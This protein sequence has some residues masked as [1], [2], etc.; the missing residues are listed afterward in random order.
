MKT[1]FSRR[2]FLKMSML[3]LG[4]AYLT[5]CGKVLSPTPP[6]SMVAPPAALPSQPTSTPV[7]PRPTSVPYVTDEPYAL[8]DFADS[9][10][11]VSD[12]GIYGI[13]SGLNSVKVNSENVNT[14]Y[15]TGQQSLEASGTIA[16]PSGSNLSIEFNVQK[17][18]GSSSYDFSNKVLVIDVFIPADSPVDWIYLEADSGARNA[19]I[20][21][22][23]I[24][25]PN[26]PPLV[27]DS[28]SYIVSLPKGQWVEAVLDIKD[29][30]SGNNPND[31]LWYASGPGG[32]LTGADALDVVKNCDV[33]KICG[34]RH[35]D[36][37]P[38][39]T[40]FLLDDLRWLERDSIKIDTSVDSLRKYAAS[41]HL[42]VG[43]YSDSYYLFGI[44][45]PKVAQA[46]PQEFNLIEF[47]SK[48]SDV[49]PSEGVFDFTKLDAMVDY[50]AGNQLAAFGYTDAENTFLPTWLWDKSFADLGPILTDYIDKVVGR[51]RGK[52]AIWN[53]FNEVVNNDGTGLRNRQSP[54]T[55][56]V[57]NGGS[58]W[59]D[60][61]DA[62][63]IK[64]AFKQARISDPGAKLLLNDY[65]TEEI[66]RRKSEFFY[67]LVKEWVK[68]GVPID[69]V[70]FEMHIEYP[71]VTVANSDWSTPRIMD[72]PAY[73]KRV[74][75]NVK[76]FADLG[77]QVVFS[78]VDVPML[79]KD[80]NPST[81]A[82]QTELKHR[83]DYEAQIFG[84]L[85]K[86]ALDNPNVIIFNTF[87]YTDKYSD[88][89]TPEWGWTG[90]GYPDLLDDHFQPKPAYVEVLKALKNQQ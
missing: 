9:F 61:N 23:K 64:A 35:T 81:S 47:S 17:Y 80:I 52:I 55:G 88:V 90:Y 63:L 53:V 51:Y 19:Q 66:G 14:I 54:Y 72:L 76:R 26:A 15:Q 59:V 20:N 34:M 65:Y 48:W 46:L 28:V 7:P 44:L 70:G 58:I 4:S 31:K 8:Y 39:S 82:G 50:A 45:E 11:G 77:I 24:K 33:F 18:L 57:P 10:E 5:A 41:T 83:L 85:M 27:Q 32:Q 74:D 67:N 62:S 87:N 60:G 29:V 56:V 71:T 6:A 73:L 12:P 22:F 42:Q 37:T 40:S 30:F 69:V 3:G 16:G 89:Y 79:I 86:V 21:A 43:S 38:I 84:G 25:D 49:E 68:E 13:G 36:G 78:E 2:D 75:A 1:R